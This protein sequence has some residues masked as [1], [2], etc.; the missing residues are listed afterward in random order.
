MRTKHA[1]YTETVTSDSCDYTL[2]CGA[3]DGAITVYNGEVVITNYTSN[4]GGK[5]IIFLQHGDKR[6]NSLAFNP[7]NKN[8][9]VS[10]SSG[11]PGGTVGIWDLSIEDDNKLIGALT[12]GLSDEVSA[13][14]FDPLNK[15]KLACAVG[16]TIQ[17]WDI[18]N[19]SKTNKVRKT[20][21][22]SKKVECLNSFSASNAPITSIAFSP[23]DQ[24]IL[25][26]A[27]SDGKIN[28]WD[29][30]KGTLINSFTHKL[31]KSSSSPCV[32]SLAFHPSEENKK[33]LFSGGSELMGS[34]SKNSIIAWN[35]TKGEGKKSFTGPTD[36]PLSIA[37][38]PFDGNML[39]CSSSNDK[40][41]AIGI[42]D[43]SIKEGIVRSLT[44]EGK[45][46]HE[47][48][49]YCVA[50]SPVGFSILKKNI[51]AS[52]S[53]DGAVKIWDPYDGKLIITF[54][55]SGVGVRAIAFAP[56]K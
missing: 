49:V 29:P 6:I 39:A 34:T 19:I 42:W 54:P 16:K 32:Y 4:R 12:T 27:S 3:D 13:V 9:L 15:N 23:F 11:R 26:C 31:E 38:N 41:G 48:I 44:S 7:T 51:L 47:K 45:G 1:D 25:A 46:G 14:A 33:I 20:W 53:E 50:F 43:S 21:D 17:I 56:K 28:I 36:K 55:T 37:L 40:V 24:K 18:S 22:P 5:N 8:I 30:Y 35:F 2:A 10:G 52:G